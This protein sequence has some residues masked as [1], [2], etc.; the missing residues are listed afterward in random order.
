MTLRRGKF[1]TVL[2]NAFSCDK[3][4]SL[5]P[6]RRL[7]HLGEHRIF[8]KV[9]SKNVYRI[10]STTGPIARRRPAKYSMILAVVARVM[11]IAKC[12]TK[13]KGPW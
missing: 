3:T 11:S 4:P 6:A 2:E 1:C 13:Q 12:K 7:A 8:R 9:N 5:R 10:L